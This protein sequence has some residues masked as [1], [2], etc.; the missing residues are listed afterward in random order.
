MRDLVPADWF[1]SSAYKEYVDRGV[2]DSLVVTAPVS[3]MAEAYYGFLRMR[4]RDPFTEAQRDVAFYA[5]RG[6]TWF[7]RQILLAH[8]LL[9]ARSPLS[10][11]ERRVL[12]LLLTDRPEKTMAT[13]LGIS[14]TTL[15]TYVSNVL[16]KFGVSGRSGLVSLWLGRDL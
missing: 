11:T 8:G 13:D 1:E 15:H 4:S 6:L 5:L 3:P 7:H 10:P 9:A 12:A 16:R 14:P 2:Y